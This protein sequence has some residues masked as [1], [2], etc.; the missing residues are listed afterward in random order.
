[1]KYGYINGED[2]FFYI[3]SI[4]DVAD[5]NI[6]S[7]HIGLSCTGED[8][9]RTLKIALL[10]R[11]LYEVEN[12]PAIR[13]DNGLQ[14]ISETFENSCK[15]LNIEHERIPYKTPNMNADIESYHR[16][17][18]EECLSINEF[19]TFA[20]AYKTVNEFIRR[21]N[22]KRIYS[23]TKYMPPAEYFEYLKITGESINIYL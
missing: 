8:A 15:Q 6:I 4:I 20:E 12:K 3:I 7:H 2:R 13:S 21:Y 5:S 18:E 22:T 16:I 11:Q 19:S 14:F 9:A 1:M 17:L 10:K 23:S